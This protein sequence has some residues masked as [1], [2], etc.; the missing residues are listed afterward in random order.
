MSSVASITG[1]GAEMMGM[2]PHS[3]IQSMWRCPCIST[4]RRA[5]GLSRR[6]NQLP[7]TSAVPIRTDSAFARRGYSTTW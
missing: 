7:L 4:M 5:S 3:P 6:T 1:D 2:P